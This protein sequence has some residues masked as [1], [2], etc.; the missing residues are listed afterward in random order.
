MCKIKKK[1]SQKS[2]IMK[3]KTKKN[4]SCIYETENNNMKQETKK[5][6]D[7]SITRYYRAVYLNLRH[8]RLAKNA[9]DVYQK[10]RSSYF[11]CRIMIQK[12]TYRVGGKN[13]SQRPHFWIQGAGKKPP[14]ILGFFFRPLAKVTVS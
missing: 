14:I 2:C 6:C 1:A 5:K 8:F 7:S 12:L 4:K 9:L 10:L 13:T 3:Q 11:L